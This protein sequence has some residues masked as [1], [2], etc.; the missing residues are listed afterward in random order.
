MWAYSFNYLQHVDRK[1][2][3]ITSGGNPMSS[4]AGLVTDAREQSRQIEVALAAT[5]LELLT[6]AQ[7]K[8]EL[9]HQAAQACISRATALLAASLERDVRPK[10]EGAFRGKIPRWQA[11]RLIAYI[12]ENIDKPIRSTD[13]IALTGMSPGHFFR[14]FKATFGQAP[15]VYIAR[16][17]VEHAQQMMLMTNDPLCLIALDCGLCDQS[18]LTR[19]FRQ[20]VGTTPGQWRREYVSGSLTDPKFKAVFPSEPVIRL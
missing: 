1:P 12:D 19:L 11:K 9:D 20:F 17:R 10:A 7:S 15:F 5:L 13:L 16:R 6:V 4:N 18:H 3:T 14:T 8:V 2:Q